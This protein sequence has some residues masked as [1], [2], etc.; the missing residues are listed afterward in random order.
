M[1]ATTATA[2]G[3]GAAGASAAIQRLLTSSRTSSC[4]RH[5]GMVLGA[6]STILPSTRSQRGAWDGRQM[7]RLVDAP[8]HAMPARHRRPPPAGQQLSSLDLVV[9]GPSQACTDR[10]RNWSAAGCHGIV[11]ARARDPHLMDDFEDDL[12][13]LVEPHVD[14][15]ASP[16]MAVIGGGD[17]AAPDGRP[18][19]AGAGPHVTPSTSVPPA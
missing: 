16:P 3:A 14:R 4:S 18:A 7:T 11:Q 1:H 15:F 19:P 8:W 6:R 2:I 5:G 13:D 12:S 10:H 9:P 17:S